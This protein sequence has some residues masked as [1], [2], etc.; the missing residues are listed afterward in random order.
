MPS[1]QINISDNSFKNF[2]I[3]I[4]GF[5]LFNST[6]NIYSNSFNM[7]S[8]NADPLV[9]SPVLYNNLTRYG[10]YAISIQNTFPNQLLYDCH[11]NWI[12]NSVIGIHS[13]NLSANTSTEIYN[14]NNQIFYTHPG[15]IPQGIEKGIWLEY[16]TKNQIS[17]N[18][19]KAT[20]PIPDLSH[21]SSLTGIRF[22]YSQ[23][24]TIKENY[25]LNFGFGM[26]GSYD[27]HQTNLL[28][29]NIKNYCEGIKCQDLTLLEQGDAGNHYSFNNVWTG[30]MTGNYRI[31][32]NPHLTII[33]DYVDFIDNQPFPFQQ[34]ISP[35]IVGSIVSN[36][37]VPDEVVIHDVV[38]KKNYDDVVFESAVYNSDPL[39]NDYSAK[40][41][42]YS[43]ADNDPKI[44]HLG[45][46]S[47]NA[48][49]KKFNELKN[50]NIGKFTKIKKLIKKGELESASSLLD[51][52]QDE[53][54]LEQNKK[55]VTQI[56]L[57][58]KI[59]KHKPDNAQRAILGPIAYK[60]GIYGGEATYMARALLNIFVDED[61]T[62]ARV[63]A[64]EFYTNGGEKNEKDVRSKY[65]F[66]YPNPANNELNFILPDNITLDKHIR[67]SDC[68][69]GTKEW[70]KWEG[71]SRELTLNTQNYSPG[72][73]FV[74]L[75]IN[76][77]M[78]QTDRVVIIH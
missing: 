24:N 1:R 57:D 35:A 71:T 65:N 32:G 17:G 54:I 60:L 22:D 4:Q 8:V 44:L 23:Q 19:I 39:F 55:T 61:L 10:S 74:T 7:I 21:A 76:N 9:S 64:P 68:Y 52:L 77:E 47:D 45:T 78:V 59:N 50:G 42:F 53:N 62:S 31:T 43:D 5:D 6:L 14:R 73:Y 70:V 12:A 13:R 75:F 49:Q 66:I 36:C 41:L 40:T 25:I 63:H 11:N 18:H 28:C 34:G 20:L 29:N 38:R 16:C 2:T 58:C 51:K 72:V 30:A 26:Y 56:Y 48:Y 67:I 37:T 33:W 46:P 27:C 69:G 3:G 15:N